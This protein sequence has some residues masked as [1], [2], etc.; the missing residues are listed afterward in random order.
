[1]QVLITCPPV[2]ANLG[3][4]RGLFESKGVKAVCPPVVQTLSEEELIDWVPRC[5]GWIIG[6]DPATRRVFEA[7]KRG[8]LKAAVKWGVGTDNVDFAAAADLQIPIANTPN[9]FGAEAAD[10]AMSYITALARETFLI[11]RQVRAGMW[12]KPTGISLDGKT[13]GVIG[14]GDIGKATAKRAL[15]A[16][17]K[18]IAY[19]PI[20]NE[21]TRF[22]EVKCSSWPDRVEECDFLVLACSL[23]ASNRHMLNKNIFARVKT[24]VRV[25]NVARGAL[26]SEDDLVSALENGTVHSVALDVFETEP[27]PLSSPLRRF[28][29]CIFG[30]HNASNTI[31]AVL[32]A[33]KRAIE[34]LFGFMGIR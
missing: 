8:A 9:M 5:E 12:P 28:E 20:F 6:D 29:Q 15:A 25:I 27:L 11:D 16:G 3:S 22:T 24:G 33:S 21:A 23:N 13:V 4:L 30:S 32:R 26:I 18:V 19:D 7:G 10:V 1:M 31:D 34:I 17:M 2:S 14:F